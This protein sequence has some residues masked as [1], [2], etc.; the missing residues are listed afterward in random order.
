MQAWVGGGE[1]TGKVIKENLN[2]VTLE[3]TSEKG[4]GGNGKDMFKE[5]Q[6][7]GRQMGGKEVK[8]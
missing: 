3:Q 2:G 7:C 1:T 6:E 5:Q 4:K 8:R